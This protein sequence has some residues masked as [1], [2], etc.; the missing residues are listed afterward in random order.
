[1][2][3]ITSYMDEWSSKSPVGYLKA[4]P[5]ESIRSLKQILGTDFILEISIPGISILRFPG[6]ATFFRV[7]VYGRLIRLSDGAVIW[8]TKGMGQ[9]TVKELKSFKDFEANNMAL[10]KEYYEKAITD[11]LFNPNYTSNFFKDFLPK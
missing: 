5:P 11:K 7:F 3:A 1:M 9:T 6:L 4:K 10:L 8:D 2:G